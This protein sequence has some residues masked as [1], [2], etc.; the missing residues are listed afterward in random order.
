MNDST[1]ILGT[2]PRNDA[3]KLDISVLQSMPDEEVF[4]IIADYKRRGYWFS[5]STNSI[6]ASA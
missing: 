4:D 5:L 3:I 6:I 2:K 1:F